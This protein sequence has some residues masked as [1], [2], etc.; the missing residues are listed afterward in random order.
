MILASSKKEDLFNKH[1][2]AELR[3]KKVGLNIAVIAD[4]NVAGQITQL[5]RLINQHTV[6]R[7]RCIIAVDDFLSYD[8]DI[9]LSRKNSDE[10]EEA[11][12]VI[13][14]AD[15]FHIG[16]FPKEIEGVPMLEYLRP[17]NTI[18]Q[19]FGSE[20]RQNAAEFYR[21]H[22]ENQ[23][24][25]VAA[26]DYT[27]IRYSPF[28]YHINMMFDSS[29][30]K[31]APK[32]E[33]TIKIVHPAT[34]REVKHTELF[35]EAMDKLVGKYDIE[36][37]IIEKKT[38]EE[39]LAIKSQAHM[40][41]DQV[42]FGIYGVSAI[43]SMAAGHVVFGGISN[44]AASIYP[45][46]PVVWVTQYDVAEKIEYY[47]INRISIV[48]RGLASKAW[49]KQHHDPVKILRQH[50]YLH[51]FVRNGHRYVPTADAQLLG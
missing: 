5:F 16:R 21:W 13:A 3:D 4:Y 9:I 14:N 12:Q 24:T 44:F 35:V 45:D 22:T 50:L 40:T 36:P 26:W 37:I 15:F 32:P 33:G 29:K 41:F 8:Q 11:R 28:F 18:V 48:E 39:C 30:I 46:N 19:Y 10:W 47:L 25:A 20:L 42:S 23:I 49:V 27:M 7:A 51:D 6:H 1:V 31:P 34:N 43:E 2:P 38:N 17:N